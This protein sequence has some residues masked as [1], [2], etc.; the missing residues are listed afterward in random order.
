VNWVTDRARKLR[1][2][3]RAADAGPQ[4]QSAGRAPQKSFLLG[5]G[6]QKGGT[7]W[8][9]HY[10]RRS[11]QFERGYRKEY[12]V[13]DSRDLP[14]EEWMR[15]RILGMADDELQKARRGE[16]ADPVQLHRASMYVDPEFYF[17]YFAGLLRSRPRIRLTADVTPDYAMLSAD[18][19]QNIKS[20]FEAR[21]V[22][23]V[24]AFLMRDPVERV[25]SQI[26]MQQGRDRKRFPAPA[27]EMVARLYDEP[28]YDMRTRYDKTIATVDSVFAEDEVYYG[29][30]ETLFT[31]EEVRKVCELT[32]I[33]FHPPNFDKMSNVSQTK[34]IEGLPDDTIRTVANHFRDVYDAVAKRFPDTN[35][36]ELWASSRYVD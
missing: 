22:R 24:A 27:E 28:S 34:P 6:C 20:S 18:R 31:D 11:P 15:D 16:P 5:V 35:L 36:T 2:R 19:M 10:L 23:T 12:H 32:G 7:T 33:K 3:S 26:R 1:D 17:D 8:L 29:F 30:Y 13:F 9:H 25:W 14:S 21:R 4:K